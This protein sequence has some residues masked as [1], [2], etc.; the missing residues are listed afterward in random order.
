MT[1]H[2]QNVF[3]HYNIAREFLKYRSNNTVCLFAEVS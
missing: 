1:F 3:D 2:D